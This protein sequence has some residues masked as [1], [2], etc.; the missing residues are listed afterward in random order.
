LETSIAKSEQPVATFT[1]HI[2]KKFVLLCLFSLVPGR[3]RSAKEV[4]MVVVA[5]E[6]K[7]QC[8]INNTQLTLLV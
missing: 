3:V 5:V 7:T 1:K 2:K 6:N 8:H 4:V